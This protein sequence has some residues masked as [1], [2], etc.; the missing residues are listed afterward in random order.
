M[1]L[2]KSVP[3]VDKGLRKRINLQYPVYANYNTSGAN[4]FYS[5]TASVSGAVLYKDIYND[6]INSSEYTQFISQ[7]NFVKVNAIEISCAP[8]FTN[9]SSLT[10]LPP[11]F[12]NLLAGVASG[13]SNYYAVARADNSMEVKMNSQGDRPTVRQYRF[14]TILTGLG[15]YPLGGTQN[16]IPTNAL[17]ASAYMY[18]VLGYLQPPAFSVAANTAIRVGVIDVFVVVDFGGKSYNQ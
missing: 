4:S 14:P 16:W 8:T 1:V 9:S 12:F 6:A 17:S 7:Y 5:F 15:G 3:L 11:V 2:F 13:P 10:D 18:A